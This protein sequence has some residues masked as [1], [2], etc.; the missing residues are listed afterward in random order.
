MALVGAGGVVNQHILNGQVVGL[1]AKAL[2]GGVVDLQALDGGLVEL[3]CLEELGLGLSTVAALAI[4]PTSTIA[5]DLSTGR[6]FHGD[7]GS[8]HGDQRTLPFL[9]A[10]G[11]FTL[12]D[13]LELIVSIWAACN[14]RNSYS[15]TSL[16]ASEVKGLTSRNADVL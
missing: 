11:G 6:L 16:E 4:P 15:S 5:V 10:E 1:D 3:V 12:E 2:H 13:D 14:K 8:G 9:V 7:V